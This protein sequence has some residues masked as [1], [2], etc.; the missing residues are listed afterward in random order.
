[1]KNIYLSGSIKQSGK[2]AYPY[3]S[4]KEVELLSKLLK[5]QN[6]NHNIFNPNNPKYQNSEV[7]FYNEELK[8]IMQCDLLIAE[9]TVRRGIGVG[10]EM[11]VAKQYGVKVI[12]ICP[13]E[14]YYYSKKNNWIHPFVENL[15]DEYHNDFNSLISFY[16]NNNI[17]LLF[18]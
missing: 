17:N 12:S 2:N 18:K 13:D 6:V 1:M 15:T 14:C 7:D 5:S 4:E 3:W 8:Y 11:Y 16:S 9:L 10:V